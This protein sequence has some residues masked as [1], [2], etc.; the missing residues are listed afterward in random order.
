MNS[1][2]TGHPRRVKR[3]ES[4]RSSLHFSRPR[5]RNWALFLIVCIGLFFRLYGINWGMPHYF[6]PDERQVM[7]KTGDISLSDMNPHFFAY[8]SLPI[9]LLRGTTETVGWVNRNVVN[10]ASALKL[11]PAWMDDIRNYFPNMNDLKQR[12]L[13]GRFLSALFSTLTI[14]VIFHLAQLLYNRKTALLAALLFALTV[15]SIQQAHFY[16]VD[17]IQTFFITCAIYYAVRASL[18]EKYR[19]YYYSALFIGFAMATKFSSLPIYLVYGFAHLIAMLEKRRRSLSH[20]MHWGLALVFSVVV[21]S[22]CMPYWILDHGTWLRDVREQANMVSGKV[23]LP[24]TIQYAHTTPFLYLIENMVLWSVG[25]PLGIAAFVG[26]AYAIARFFK[27]PLDIGNR[28][29]L[30]W[31]VPLFILNSTFEVKFL[32][33]TL[34]LLPFFCIFAAKWLHGI[35]KQIGRVWGR[36]AT[37]LVVGLTALWALAFLNVYNR[38]DTRVEASN[39]VYKN[40]PAGARIVL[41]SGWDDSLPI[42]TDEGNSTR[43]GEQKKLEIYQEPDNAQKASKM[44]EILT[45]GDVIILPSKRH[46]GSVLRVPDRYPI[47]NNFYRALFSEK[48]GFRYAASF[49]NP[50]RLGRMVFRDET[51]D[52]SFSVYEHPKVAVFVKQ[53]VLTKEQILT[54]LVSPPPEIKQLSYEDILTMEPV[55]RIGSR[56]NFPVVRWILAVE[57]I[58]FVVFPLMFV[59]FHRFPHAGYPLAKAGGLLVVG[60]L[61]WLIASLRIFP[62]SQT[63]IWLVITVVAVLNGLLL[64]RHRSEIRQFWRERWWS[65][66]G[67]ELLFFSVLTIFLLLKSYNPDIFWSESS[68]DFGFMNAVLRTD[69]FPPIDPWI[70]GEG[71]NYYYFGQYLAGFLTK[72]TGVEARYGYNLFFATIPTFVALSIASIAITLTRRMWIGCLCVIIT[73]LVGNL[74]GLVQI[75]RIFVNNAKTT[76]YWDLARGLEWVTDLFFMLGRPASQFRFFRSA[77]ELINPTVHEFPFWSYNFMDLHAHTIATFIATFCLALV[78]VFYRN[79]INQSGIFG[80]GITAWCTVLVAGIG[81]GAMIPT[82]S[83]D[84]PTYL[85]LVL[86]ILMFFWPRSTKVEYRK[87]AELPIEPLPEPVT[88]EELPPAAATPE[89]SLVEEIIPITAATP[90]SVETVE[91]ENRTQT[92][93][94]EAIPLAIEPVEVQEIVTVAPG[95]EPVNP[96]NDTDQ[97]EESD[98]IPDRME[99]EILALAPVEEFPQPVPTKARRG[100]R[101]PVAFF[102]DT[103]SMISHLLGA[104][105][106]KRNFSQILLPWLILIGVSI[107]LYLPYLMHFSRKDMGIGFLFEHKQTTNFDG[108]FTMFGFYL[109]ILTTILIKIWIGYER[110]RGRS[111][112]RVF[113]IGFSYVA[114]LIVMLLGGLFFLK[115][116]YSVFLY[117]LGMIGLIVYLGSK[118][119]QDGDR[120]FVYLISFMAFAITAGCEIVYIKDFYQGGDHRRFNTIFKFY[121]QAWFFFALVASYLVGVRRRVR[122]F[123]ATRS[124]LRHR[125]AGWAWNLVFLFFLGSALIFTVMGPYARRHHDEYAREKLPLTLDG[126]AYMKT[127]RLQQEYR[128]IEWLSRNAPSDAVILEAT[129]A[130][131]LYEF[132]RISANTGIPTVLGW[133]SH[134]DQ[135]EYKRDTGRI[136]IG[137][138]TI[139]DSLDIPLVLEH[140]R[141]Y[142]VNLIFVGKTERKQY[143]E[144]GLNKFSELTDYMTPVYA[145]SEVII[146]QVNDYGIN[147]DFAKVASGNDALAEL[148]QRLIQEEA[149]RIE[150]ERQAELARIEQIRNSPPRTMYQGGEGEARGQF[151]EPRSLDVDSEGFV[152]I[153]DFRN[154][155]VQKFDNLGNFLFLWESPIS[156]EDKG[157]NDLCDI[158]V[159][160]AGV[161][162][163]DTFNNRIQK[164]DHDGQY[165]SEWRDADGAFFYPRGLTADGNGFLYVADSGRNRIVKLTT[166]GKLVKSIGTLGKGPSQ[167]VEPIG[168]CVSKGEVFVNDA[169]NRRVQVFDSELNYLREWPVN[170]WE[171]NVF[172]EPYIVVDQQDQVWIS[173]PNANRLY[174]TDRNG[175]LLKTV[176]QRPDGRRLTLPMGLSVLPD[177]SILV[178]ETH[179]HMITKIPNPP[180]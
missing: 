180:R 88:S 72:F 154:H 30:I 84:Y 132:G 69:Y 171:G 29:I 144:T 66:L 43:Y 80:S 7:Y 127:G 160:K 48:L 143:S 129:G 105:P 116:D 61:T 35:N 6:H 133:W 91:L 147:V 145:N 13:T 40:I 9:Y 63:L 16:I 92:V 38:T 173:D 68:M 108:F 46:Y 57:L 47:S 53:S 31:V 120:R 169:K 2:K 110:G 115:I 112:M 176:D 26:F 32:R 99:Q 82:N 17:G 50:P 81:F 93:C 42:G 25:I 18:G 94:E 134:V 19:D 59:I 79:K 14:I 37:T 130:D 54:Y 60:Y 70:E 11:S 125:A 21:M 142:N 67:Y 96:V 28:I 36:A 128:A 163:L 24:Y 166:Q 65:V 5:G 20:Q 85:L 102:R 106:I 4:Y 111:L 86:L 172:V 122:M 1:L 157:F 178:V 73:I 75:V 158:A 58:G 136:K 151:R 8:G 146:Y 149:D 41:E 175:T 174:V 89:S 118:E 90:A 113:G 135:R 124:G 87:S 141:N 140:L 109:F 71:I 126:H 62:F 74:D 83:W 77:H 23:R 52:E 156:E 10:L 131:Y 12:T 119:L 153:A 177:G 15:L 44:A 33:Y 45:E 56:V 64:V 167:F 78:F 27:K 137:I 97:P 138:K 168:I 34:P 104:I 121:M 39:W 3:M 95:T 51:A 117:S 150:Q 139:Y 148:Q 22:I 76:P 165:I 159:D 100:L 162:V 161:Y 170:G 103:V 55:D 179:R 101:F 155:R 123:A 49:S 98:Q 114:I 107:A 152:Y 164:Y